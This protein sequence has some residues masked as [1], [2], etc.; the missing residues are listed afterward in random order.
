V[1]ERVIVCEDNADLRE[2]VCLVLEQAG[3]AVQPVGTA[4]TCLAQCR[5]SAPDVLLVDLSLPDA[6][7]V[8]LVRALRR[9]PRL[10]GLTVI[11]LS[12]AKEREREVLAAG[13]DGFLLKPVGV[14]E[15]LEAV[16]GSCAAGEPLSRASAEPARRSAPYSTR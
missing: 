13:A 6:S 2:V 16:E 5:F 8:D 14:T 11:A 9:D 4:A 3:Y 12:G 10:A 7:G 15:L 1:N